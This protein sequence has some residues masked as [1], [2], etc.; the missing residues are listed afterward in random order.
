MDEDTLAFV[1]TLLAVASLLS[2]RRWSRAIPALFTPTIVAKER[3]IVE[4]KRETD[5][6]SDV[7]NFTQHSKNTR[8][9]NKMQQ[10]VDQM[11]RDRR[12]KGWMYNNAPH[13]FAW[14][15]Q[16][17]LIMPLCALYGDRELIMV[18]EF[19]TSL[20]FTRTAASPSPWDSGWR[21]VALPVFGGVRSL[22]VGIWFVLVQFAASFVLRVLRR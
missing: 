14:V 13:L 19:A 2:S 3:A 20:A 5:K 4:L 8:Q 7:S 1:V 16:L 10:E 17:G 15:L 21:S 22:G 18:P 11:R 12:A 6:L 9:L